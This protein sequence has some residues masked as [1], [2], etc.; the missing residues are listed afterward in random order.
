MTDALEA[1]PDELGVKQIASRPTPAGRTVTPQDVANVVAMMCGPDAEM[2]RGQV[3]LVDGGE[4][5]LH[6]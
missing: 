6:Q 2:I 3:I 4:T 5:L 1:F